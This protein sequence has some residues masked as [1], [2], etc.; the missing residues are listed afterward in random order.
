[1]T[2]QQLPELNRVLHAIHK[3]P[4]NYPGFYIIAQDKTTFKRLIFSKKNFIVSRA[5]EDG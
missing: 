3:H 1:M 2:P 4:Q 5:A